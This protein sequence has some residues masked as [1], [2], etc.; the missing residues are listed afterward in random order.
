MNLLVLFSLILFL[1][2]I[3]FSPRKLHIGFTLV[4]MFI[5]MWISNTATTALMIPMV[6]T[7]LKELEQHGVGKLFEEGVTEEDEV[8]GNTNLLP[9]H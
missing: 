2:Q 1:F 5:S 8:L 7:T 9:F 6:F 4:T 3:G